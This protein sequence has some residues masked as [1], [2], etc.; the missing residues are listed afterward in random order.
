MPPRILVNEDSEIDFKLLEAEFRRVQFDCDLRQA[1]SREQFQREL[2]GFNP[3]LIISDYYLIGFNALDALE[4]VMKDAPDTPFIILTNAL[5]EET[6]VECMKRGAT[7]YVLKNRLPRLVA[8]LRTTLERKRL[9]K[10]NARIQREHE[11]LFRLTPDLF[12]LATVD[13]TL[14]VVN[15][16]WTLRLGFR[17]AELVERPL[18]TLVHPD[19]RHALDSWWSTL[20]SR[21]QTVAPFA[22]PAAPAS[23]ECRL[24]HKEK[25]FRYIQWSAKP[26]PSENKVYAYGHDVTEFKRAEFALRESEARFRRMADSAPVYIWMSDTS[27][28]FVYFNQPWLEFTGR[29]LSEELGSGWTD[30]LH[31]EDC[32]RCLQAYEES[33]NARVPFRTEYRLRRRDNH[34]RWVVSHGTPRYDE[35]GNFAGFIGSCF[36]VTDQHEV[37]AHLAY[38]AI[39]QAA[40]ASFGRFALAQH[41]FAELTQEAARLVSD[42]LRIDRAA[43]LALDGDSQSLVLAA[44]AG[45]SFSQPNIPLGNASPHAIDAER[46]I[47]L[48]EDPRNFPGGAALGAL[49]IRSGV[50]VPVGSVKSTY[51]FLCALS[52]EDRLFN[53]EAV[54]FM[55]GLANILSTVHQRERAEAALQESEQKLLQSQ[56]MEAVG[57]LAGGVAHDFNNLLTAIRCYGDILH[58]DL[59]TISPELRS[60]ASEILKATARASALVRQLLAFSRKQVLQPEYLDLN[61]VFGDLKDLIRSLLSENITLD[62]LPNTDAVTIQADR[63]QIEQVIINLAI[64]ARDAMPQGGSLTLRT[65]IRTIRPDEAIELAAGTYAEMSVSDTGMGMSEEVKAKL[66]QPFFTTKPK[67]RG[68]G[69]GL[70]TCAVV[71]KHYGGGIQFDSKLGA[72]TTF[73]VLIPLV[74][75]P[76][77]NMDFTFDDEPGVGTETILLVED[78]EAI[79]G[80]TAA[81]LRSLGYQVYPLSGGNE[82]LEFCGGG[83]APAVDLL[84][85]DIVMPQMGGRELAERM[86]KMKP[87]LRVLFMSGYVDD[88][89]ILHAVREA[90]IPFL[91]KPFTR[92]GLAKKVREALDTPR[93]AAAR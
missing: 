68:T 17:E 39:K 63:S 40:L 24:V 62:I 48:S 19:D 67:G 1:V 41:T 13:G 85:T 88:P 31:P 93:A 34:Y 59:S 42:T 16:A 66:F 91:E 29:K 4:I 3:E 46:P 77:L 56:K 18:F 9:A 72:G 81:I 78:D 82:A 54:D 26:F 61:H 6:A 70:A 14:Q 83:H 43:I 75:P 5:N 87:D 57:L 49:G 45:P 35:H 71:L 21:T 12:C 28:A 69:L 86:L 74:Q 73:R 38:R 37:E 89:V 50:A 33:F 51:G 8:I 27:K 80:V 44:Y 58:E 36:D 30:N 76:A 92:D 64:N 11:Q 22:H 32:E 20:V 47:H 65:G 53:R 23:F 55:Q 15:P 79:R 60:K 7:D 2:H 25:G 84:L 52:D 10:E 90:S